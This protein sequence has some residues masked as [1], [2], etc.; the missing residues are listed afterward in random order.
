MNLRAMVVGITSVGLACAALSSVSP[1]YA[2]TTTTPVT[3]VDEVNQV[4]NVSVTLGPGDILQYGKNDC[5]YF[6]IRAY[7]SINNDAPK[8]VG[9][10]EYQNVVDGPWLSTSDQA[11]GFFNP[12]AVRYTAPSDGTLSDSFYVVAAT[13]GRGSAGYLVT[14]TISASQ[15]VANQSPIPDWVQ[16]YGRVNEDAPCEIGWNPSWQ[17][18]AEPVTGGWVCTRSIPSL[19]S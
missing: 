16:A 17:A 3:C 8:T 6:G 4:N 10:V 7:G 9:I 12:V 18:W 5:E 14:V 19:G 11:V 13:L 15:R 1:V 2:A